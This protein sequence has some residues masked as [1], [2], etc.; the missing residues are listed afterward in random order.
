MESIGCGRCP[1]RN[2]G[3]RRWPPPMAPGRSQHPTPGTR[4]IWRV[5][6]RAST[7][8]A[9]LPRAGGHRG[10]SSPRVAF[11]PRRAGAPAPARSPL[12]QPAPSAWPTRLGITGNEAQHV[13]RGQHANFLDATS[14][15][16]GVVAF[17]DPLA[18]VAARRVKGVVF[19]HRPAMLLQ[20]NHVPAR[21]PAGT[22]QG[23]RPGR[24]RR[25]PQH[26]HSGTTRRL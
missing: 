5:R 11:L 20:G 17:R 16:K 7:S 9:M 24:E 22:R 23:R 4:P 3:L 10:G 26:S 25:A 12:P 6:P 21:W 2:N 8:A 19:H 15:R 14:H 13:G 1:R 18:V